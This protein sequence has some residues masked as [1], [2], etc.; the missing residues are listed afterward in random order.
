[1][2]KILPK[3]LPIIFVLFLFAFLFPLSVSADYQSAYND[4]SYNYTVYRTTYND[5]Q[6]AK[7]TFLTYHTLTAQNDAVNKLRAVLKAR[8]QVMFVYFDLLQEKLNGTPGVPDDAKTTFGKVKESEKTW[9]TDHQKKIDAAASLDDLNSASSEFESRYH[10]MDTETKQAIGSVLSAKENTLGSK[11]DT[12]ITDLQTKT[13][14]IRQSGENTS[15]ADRGV[16]D[17]KNKLNLFRTKLSAANDIFYPKYNSD[18]ID[19][20]KGEQ[21]FTQANQYLREAVSFLKE[22]IK[23]FTG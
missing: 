12:F 7:S 2:E 9:L 20:F 23:S 22:I 14:E 15:F 3:F 21:Q 18:Q 8:N 5:Y 17:T 6:V 10:Q 4:Y 13:A 11:V 1:M 19:I 16:I